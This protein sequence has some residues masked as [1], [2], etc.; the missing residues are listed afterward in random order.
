FGAPNLAHLPLPAP[1][2]SL[3]ALG[4]LP[5]ANVVRSAAA[6]PLSTTAAVLAPPVSSVVR[7]ASPAS[8]TPSVGSRPVAAAAALTAA[9]PAG[10][11]AQASRRSGAAAGGVGTYQTPPAPPL[12][13]FLGP[14]SLVLQEN[15]LAWDLSLASLG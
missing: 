11:L 2:A 13:P 9:V 3:R 7:A 14:R 8:P 15:D 1:L 4:R 12:V 10:P 5:V 6:V